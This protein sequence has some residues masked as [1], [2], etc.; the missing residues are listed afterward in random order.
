MVPKF[1]QLGNTRRSLH[2][3]RGREGERERGGGG[4]GETGDGG[5]KKHTHTHKHTHTNTLP[6]THSLTHSLTHTHTHTHTLTHSHTQTLTLSLSHTHTHTESMRELL[7][8]F[9]SHVP[10][11]PSLTSTPSVGRVVSRNSSHILRMSSM[12]PTL[13][14][15]QGGVSKSFGV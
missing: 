7:L 2:K 8:T 12:L 1:V 9:H 13:R 3:E 10:S 5:G 14:A 11:L 15:S 6:L 4:D